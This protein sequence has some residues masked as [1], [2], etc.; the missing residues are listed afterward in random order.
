MG[1]TFRM[2]WYVTVLQGLLVEKRGGKIAREA[3][4]ELTSMKQ[5]AKRSREKK[6]SKCRNLKLNSVVTCRP[7][8]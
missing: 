5:Y 8:R 2:R 3:S 1:C 7:Y 6:S 4:R